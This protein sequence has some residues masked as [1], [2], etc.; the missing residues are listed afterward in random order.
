MCSTVWWRRELTVKDYH[1]LK[2]FSSILVGRSSFSKGKVHPGQFPVYFRALCI[3]FYPIY[4]ITF[5][6]SEWV[7]SSRLQQS[8]YGVLSDALKHSWIP[9][10]F[11][12]QICRFLSSITLIIL[13]IG[14]KTTHHIHNRFTRKKFIISK[15]LS[16]FRANKKVQ[17]HFKTLEFCVTE[18]EL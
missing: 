7:S 9:W 1:F 3:T 14:S 5:L 2:L 6:C 18:L 11:L 12:T 17:K 10:R 4:I 13:R 15:S 8:W 16:F